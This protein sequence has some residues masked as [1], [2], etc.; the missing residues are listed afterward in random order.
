MQCVWLIF[1]CSPC[2]K[3]L[4]V[5]VDELSVMQATLYCIWGSFLRVAGAALIQISGGY[6]ITHLTCDL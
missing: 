1:Q 6:A 4:N 3:A 2:V 5:E